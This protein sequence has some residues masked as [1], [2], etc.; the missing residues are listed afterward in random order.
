MNSTIR[1]F[2]AADE[3]PLTRI[4]HQIY[5]GSRLP[6]RYFQQQANW[7]KEVNGRFLTLLHQIQP[8][9]YASALPV[10]GLPHLYEM[11]GFVAP[12]HHRQG[13]GSR[14]FTQL[15][16]SMRGTG[17]KQLSRS[18]SNTQTATSHFLRHHQFFVE[19]EESLMQLS[20]LQAQSLDSTPYILRSISPEQFCMLYDQSFGNSPWYQPFTVA[21]VLSTR[22]K[23]DALYGLW[24]NETAVGF[25]WLRYPKKTVAE[26]EPIGIVMGKQGKGYGRLLI[27]HLLHK[28]QQQGI[29][30]VQLGVWASNAIAIHLYQQ[31]GFRHQN[32][33]TYFAFNLG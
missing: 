16:Q 29:Q 18:V 26:I 8:I 10:P 17:A 32:T 25:V 20:G 4:H 12:A 5:G 33:T 1:Q 7:S 13:F 22:Q 30:Q 3:R 23:G 14:L 19:H 15:C 21:E 28:L 2:Q 27:Q 11:A 24:I 9:G 31:F 6:S